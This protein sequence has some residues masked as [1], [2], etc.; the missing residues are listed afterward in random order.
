MLDD[1]QLSISFPNLLPGTYRNSS[2]PTDVYNCIAWAA[3]RDDHWW[4]PAAGAGYYWPVS[5]PLEYTIDAALKLFESLGFV[6]CTDASLEV[7]FEKIVIYGERGGYTHAARQLSNGKWTSKL[8]RYQD[9]DHDQ[10]E[11]LTGGDYGQ[12]VF[13]MKRPVAP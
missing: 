7:Q 5:V 2:P 3:G 11:S 4:E 6:T 1:A 9:I 8:G 12:I 13:I 10:P